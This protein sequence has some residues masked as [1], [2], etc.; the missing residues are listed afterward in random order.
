VDVDDFFRG[1]EQS[2]SVFNALRQRIA[3]LPD[4]SMA[5]TKSQVAFKRQRA[6]AWA[7]IP[8]RYLRGRHAPLVLSLAFRYRDQSPR[9]KQVVEPAPGRFMH[10]LE[11]HT[12]DDLDEE[13]TQWLWEA[14]AEAA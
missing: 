3:E 8:D 1:Y 5:V 4:V 10:H 13:T 14:W 11:L 6:F 7:W 12:P 9:W 2:R